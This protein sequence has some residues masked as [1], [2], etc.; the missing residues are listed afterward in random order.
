MPRLVS[1]KLTDKTLRSLTAPGKYADGGGLYLQVTTSGSKSWV[2]RYS[3]SKGTRREAG[4]GAYP[5]VTLAEAR[6]KATAMALAVSN[7]L[8]PLEVKEAIAAKKAASVTFAEA[9]EQYV[10][11]HAPSWKTAKR[12]VLWRGMFANHANPKIGKLRVQ[13][14]TTEDVLRVVE[15]LWLPHTET[16]TK[17]RSHISRV[18]GWCVAKGYRPAGPNPAAWEGCLEP[19]LPKPNKVRRVVHHASLPHKE[20]AAFM[21]ELSIAKSGRYRAFRL[22]I[23]TACR[24]SEVLNARWAEFDLGAPL[25]TIPAERMKNGKPHRVP[26]APSVVALLRD[27]GQGE[28]DSYLFPGSKPGKPISNMTFLNILKDM[29]RADIT[30]HGFRSSFRVWAGECTNYPR[31]VVEAALAHSVSGSAVEAAYYRS[32]LLD[33][34]RALM[35]DWASYCVDRAYPNGYNSK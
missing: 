35:V 10:I 27:I 2:F 14:I 29:E 34:R 24:T 19:L 11:T 31:D 12:A 16:A 3:I 32:D 18:L 13:E 23:L 15:P 22:L 6:R 17:L 25:W 33:K 9:A 28:G 26:L 8:D 5:L 1:N 30:P 20:V 7:D 21:T 4:L